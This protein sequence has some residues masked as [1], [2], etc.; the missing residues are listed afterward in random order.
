M[1][2]RTDTLVARLLC[3]QI[4]G[5]EIYRNKGDNLAGCIAWSADISASENMVLR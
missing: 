4:T 5:A 3:S 2:A 1:K